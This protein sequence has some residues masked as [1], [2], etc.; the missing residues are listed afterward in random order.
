MQPTQS[1]SRSERRGTS[2][3]RERHRVAIPTWARLTPQ[4]VPSSSQANLV[5]VALSQEGLQPPPARFSPT[6]E[7]AA[8]LQPLGGRAWTAHEHAP[9][10]D[11]M[12][13]DSMKALPSDSDHDQRERF[14][15]F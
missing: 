15:N 12:Y 9:T 1:T 5:N 3:V 2:L 6:V 11:E 8:A 10:L 13:Y 4:P 14:R 7:G